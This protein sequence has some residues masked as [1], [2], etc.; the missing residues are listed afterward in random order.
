M[1]YYSLQ[2]DAYQA[3]LYEMAGLD[4]KADTPSPSTEWKKQWQLYI[5]P[6]VS[7]TMVSL[8]VLNTAYRNIE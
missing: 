2:L 3:R 5:L 1:I 4:L 6:P 8:S 7:K